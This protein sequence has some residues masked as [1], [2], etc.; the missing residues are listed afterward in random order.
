[1]TK[2]ELVVKLISNS[3][4]LD[5]ELQVKIMRRGIGNAVDFTLA[6]PIVHVSALGDFLCVEEAHIRCCPVIRA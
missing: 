1:M 4:D 2:R 6:I 3:D 5:Q